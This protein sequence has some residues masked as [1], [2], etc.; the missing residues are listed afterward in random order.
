MY[1]G[2]LVASTNKVIIPLN[3]TF[4]VDAFFFVLLRRIN[5][6]WYPQRKETAAPDIRDPEGMLET[7]ASDTPAAFP[8][9]E[10]GSGYLGLILSTP[11]ILSGGAR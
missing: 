3:L 5:P 10:V 11:P 1:L 2:P 8:H 9:A 6:L 4:S 7:V